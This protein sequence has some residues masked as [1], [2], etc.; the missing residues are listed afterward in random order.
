MTV[1]NQCALQAQQDSDLNHKVMV[2]F[3]QIEKRNTLRRGNSATT[4]TSMCATHVP[5]PELNQS[6]LIRA[7][8]Q[9]IAFRRVP[10]TNRSPSIAFDG[11]PSFVGRR[12]CL[13]PVLFREDVGRIFFPYRNYEVGLAGIRNKSSYAD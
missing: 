9:S 7:A 2:K 3:S 13:I 6:R 12:Y 8:R 10:F 1:E 4:L 11:R 5:F